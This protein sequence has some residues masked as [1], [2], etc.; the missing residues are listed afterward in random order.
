M[1]AV[2][3]VVVPPGLY[4]TTIV[5]LAPG[6]MLEP[7][8]HVPPVIEKTPAAGPAVLTTAGAAVRTSAP[9]AAAALLTVMVPVLMLVPP[10]LSAGEGAEMVGVAPV[11]VN[12]AALLVPPV[13]V[14]VTFL[15][16]RVGLRAIV[17]VAVI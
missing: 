13:V 11:M 8:A 4:C 6:L 16:P 5:Q 1:C 14:T 10:V 15:T 17:N 3:V 9:L 7:D 2:E 12:V